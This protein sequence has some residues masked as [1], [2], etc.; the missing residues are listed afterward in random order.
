MFMNIC[1]KHTSFQ[2]ASMILNIIIFCKDGKDMS[3]KKTIKP[4]EI[5]GYASQGRILTEA[6]ELR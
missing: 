3:S 5:F 2:K 4:N 6:T 1:L